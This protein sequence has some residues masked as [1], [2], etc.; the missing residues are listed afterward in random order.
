MLGVLLVA[1]FLL[2][3]YDG[4]YKRMKHEKMEH[5]EDSSHAGESLATYHP[6]SSSSYSASGTSSQAADDSS[7][8]RVTDNTDNSLNQSM[9]NNSTSMNFWVRHDV[10]SPPNMTLT[11]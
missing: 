11:D 8:V 6:P 4:E 9:A 7:L 5:M 1:A 2:L 10:I 3:F